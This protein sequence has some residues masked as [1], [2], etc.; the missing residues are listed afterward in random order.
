[1]VADEEENQLWRRRDEHE[2]QP[3]IQADPA[4]ENRLGEAADADARMAM[5]PSPAFKNLIDRIADFLTLRLRPGA[6]LFQQI[7]S[8]SCLQEGLRC[9][10]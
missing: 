9:L 1:M 4:L 6:D 8:D 2:C 10:R 7:L 5:R 3:V